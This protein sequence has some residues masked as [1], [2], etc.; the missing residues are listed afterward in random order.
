MVVQ[1]MIDHGVP[2]SIVNIFSIAAYV[3]FPNLS[4][5]SDSKDM[6][7]LTKTIA[8]ELGPH[9]I[10]VNSVNP[11]VVLTAMSQQSSSEPGS[12]WKLKARHP[13]RR[14]AE[15]ED[16]VNSVLFLFSDC[17]SSTSGQ[18]ILVDTG[19]LAS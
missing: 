4:V 1:G 2:G 18:S 6:T 5:Y 12:V 9:K 8:M 17:S 11:T 10:W 15:L 13:L 7:M 14:F 19:Y 3:T 16:V